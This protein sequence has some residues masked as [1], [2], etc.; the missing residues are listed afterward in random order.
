[1]RDHDHMTG[2]YRGAAHSRCNLQLRKQY[3]LPVFLHNFRG[4]DCHLIMKGMSHFRGMELKIIGQGMEKYLCLRF[5]RHIVFK[6]SL[7]FMG[8]SLE[9]LAKNL[10]DAGNDKFKLL[11][12]SFPH[13]SPADIGL[14]LRKGVYP[15]DYMDT[16]DKFN[17]IHLPAREEFFSR[18]RNQ[19][20][21]P[22]DYAHAQNVW[23]T[24]GI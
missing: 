10:A 18:L 14:L 4:Y 16:W 24:F 20:C 5:G 23:T 8:S 15:Y 9:K 12:A 3:Q 21:T 1:M 17:E 22:E 11:F 2:R 6:D 19:D 7:M 13:N